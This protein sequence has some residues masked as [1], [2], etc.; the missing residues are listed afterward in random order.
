MNHS[1][2]RTCLIA[3]S[4]V[5]SLSIFA[6]KD[7]VPKGW[8]MLDKT[9]DGYSGISVDKAYD[10]VRSKKLKSKTVIVA[11]IDSGVD[12]L[13][14]D[15]KSILW[16]N[17]KEI[18]GN[19]IDDDK[20]GYV[21]DYYGWNFLG[22][23][24]GRNVEQDS[25]E[26]ARVYHQFKDKWGTKENVKIESL[27]PAEA[28]E[29]QAWVRAKAEIVGDVNP[30]EVLQLRRMSKT[31]K[32][33]DSVIRQELKKE[34][35]SCKELSAY[36]TGNTSALRVKEIL[37]NIC[38]ANDNEE[39]T[40]QQIL[41]QLEGDLNK[42][43]ASETAPKDYRGEI[44]K[45]TY[46][47]FNDK[48]YGNSNVMVSNKS[49]LHGTHVS[50][51]IAAV[52]K[53]GVGMDGVADNV[54]IM[55]LRAVPDGDEHDKDIALAIRY[56]VDNGA[57]VINMS[58]G[59]SFSPEK[60]WVDDAVRYAESKGVLLVHAA[61]NDAKNLD[62][63]FNY[64]TPLLLDNKRPN[65]WI[66]V[67][68]SGDPKAGGLTANFSNYG[69]K[70]VD[71][72]APGVKIY[73]SVPGGN[74]YQNLQGTSMASPVVAGLAAFIMSYYPNL[75]AAQVKTVIE[76]SSKD[77]GTEVRNPGTDEMVKLSE[78]SRSGGII[79]A[80]EAI[81]LASVT[82]GEKKPMVVKPTTTVKPKA[83]G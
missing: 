33:G 2:K 48:F 12:T 13:H 16:K 82:K 4:T 67:G 21:D 77:P 5:L 63:T 23:R 68:A 74:T 64:P 7:E 70:E 66:T 24:D 6:Q 38:K 44:V 31:M 36:S 57:Q 3:F 32:T 75:S 34:E 73:S 45:D 14:E 10:F 17:T 83:K 78:L 28:F 76:K 79:N 52:R 40:N 11:V 35:Y 55:S 60:K 72:F 42:M 50:G 20:N 19:G 9:K 59:K 80:Y 29:Y 46:E 1:L 61:G 37:L 54:R 27:S 65:N 8:H 81:K 41:D 18:P 22:G 53:N 51:I 39:I 43:E 49:A 47:D 26:A 56:A 30:L 62:T 69:K 25:Y 15:L 58:F 71:V